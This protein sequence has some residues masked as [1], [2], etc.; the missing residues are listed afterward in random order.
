[1]SLNDVTLCCALPLTC[2]ELYDKA[3]FRFCHEH[4]ISHPRGD[5][6]R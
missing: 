1:M 2:K 6:N 3:M 5:T 4:D